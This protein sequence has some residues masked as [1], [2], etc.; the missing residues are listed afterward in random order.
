MLCP[1]C[2]SMLKDGTK[3]CPYCDIDIK[4]YN[5]AL[6]L[7][8]SAPKEEYYEDYAAK[9][10][11]KEGDKTFRAK[12]D[13]NIKKLRVILP[14]MLASF[15]IF[16]VTVVLIMGKNTISFDY[17]FSDIKYSEVISTK[18]KYKVKLKR[19]NT[20]DVIFESNCGIL[21]FYDGEVLWNLE[22]E[23]GRC[24]ITAKYKKLH[25]SK[26]VN[27]IPNLLNKGEMLYDKLDDS[28]KFDTDLDGIS[29]NDEVN[30][31]NT[32]PTNVDTDNDGLSDYNEIKLN[33]DPNNYSSLNNDKTD[34]DIKHSYS[35]KNKEVS[36]YTN[37]SGNV[38]N[39]K[40]TIIKKDLNING[41]LNKIYN[42]YSEG[43]SSNNK[44]TIDY[45]NLK[46]NDIKEEDLTIYRYYLESN[47]LEKMMSIVDKDNKTISFS[48]ILFGYYVLGDKNIDGNVSDDN[49]ISIDEDKFLLTSDSKFDIN[50]DSL[51]SGNYVSINNTNG[52]SYGIHSFVKDFY[53]GKIDL[54]KIKISKTGL[55]S[56]VYNTNDLKYALGFDAFGEE[57]F[58]DFYVLKGNNLEISSKY[59]NE[60][61]SSNIYIIEKKEYLK[62]N[63]VGIK[64]Y[65]DII[66][67]DNFD[68][69]SSNDKF[70][71]ERFNNNDLSFN[72]NSNDGSNFI[73]NIDNLFNKNRIAVLGFNSEKGFNVVNGI[74]LYMDV[75]NYNIYYIGVYDV[76]YKDEIRYLKLRCN[77]NG[78]C[79]TLKNGFYDTNDSVVYLSK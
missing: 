55:H 77:V 58:K 74:S 20:K 32:D 54:S 63:S 45:S 69:L 27:I 44:L 26:T 30:K 56:Y 2:R 49:I 25:I 50:K 9:V 67:N 7:R 18:L 51:N 73:E 71:L 37:E 14:V 59:K 79:L 35:I 38:V 70:L 11:T 36:F 5:E 47:N 57:T 42:I 31:Y 60:I 76:N 19:G 4:K 34:S 21:H 64:Y 78:M 33:T 39:S 72:S 22:N 61:E 40:I 24:T 15:V 8:A 13:E 46:L 66:F 65:E 1:R 17:S 48:N 16:V 52:H 23:S 10:D 3:K 6:I 28:N 75:S 53:N 12:R 62:E 43:A 68:L 41:V 29:D